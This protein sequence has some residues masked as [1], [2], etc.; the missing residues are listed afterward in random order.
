V[1]PV[2]QIRSEAAFPNGG[3]QIYIR[4]GD[5]PDIH[6]H[7]LRSPDSLD[8]TVFQNAQQLGLRVQWHFTNLI[9]EERPAV[10]Q[11]EPTKT[12]LVCSSKGP[13][14]MAEQFALN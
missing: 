2:E 10:G 4:R 6:R 9:E 5:H 14:F 13:A 1:Q 11:F 3:D 8:L 7:C 12:S